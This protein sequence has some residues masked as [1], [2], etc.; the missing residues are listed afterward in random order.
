MTLRSCIYE[1]QVMHRR[2]ASA[3]HQFRYSLFLMYVD[4]DELP[5]LFRRRLFWS[6]GGPNLAW[7]RRADHLG[8]EDRPLAESVRDAVEE[9]L[10][11]RP[12]GSIGLLTSFRYFG[13]VMNPLSLHYCFD[14]SGE[15]VEAV[16]ADVSNTPWNERHLYVLDMRGQPSD[17]DLTARCPKEFHVSPFFDMNHEYAWTLSTPGEALNVR[18]EA[19]NAEEL[20]FEAGLRMRRIPLG[21]LQLARALVRYPLM[22]VQVFARIYW[23][24]LRLWMKR[25]P[26]VPHPGT[27]VSRADTGSAERP[28]ANEHLTLETQEAAL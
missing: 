27:S 11:F 18:I 3:H 6:S 26:Y 7:F 23:Q 20:R 22:T 15:R 21:G 25:V 28:P 5:A 19:R 24:A 9:R 16:V 17:R 4:L 13:F 2:F 12:S 10:G 14:D 1:G 8:D